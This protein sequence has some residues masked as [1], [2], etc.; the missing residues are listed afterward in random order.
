MKIYVRKSELTEM[1]NI[2]VGQSVHIVIHNDKGYYHYPKP[3]TCIGI[4]TQEDGSLGYV[5]DAGPMAT[6]VYN[7]TELVKT[8]IK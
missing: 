4:K 7:G 6:F 3:E 5:F 1:K 2:K 8:E